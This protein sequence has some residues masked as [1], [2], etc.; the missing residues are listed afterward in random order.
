MGGTAFLAHDGYFPKIV[1]V[2]GQLLSRGR[3]QLPE[4]EICF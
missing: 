1:P 2:G 3:T 4:F